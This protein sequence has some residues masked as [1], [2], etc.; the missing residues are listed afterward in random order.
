MDKKREKYIME[1]EK[2]EMK[3]KPG[4]VLPWLAAVL[5]VAA[6]AARAAVFL[7]FLITSFF[8]CA[9]FSLS[10]KIP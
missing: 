10:R 4:K 1:N 6:L 9:T 8:P 5:L 2:N 7:S 3:K